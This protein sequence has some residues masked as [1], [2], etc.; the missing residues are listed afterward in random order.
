MEEQIY[1]VAVNRYGIRFVNRLLSLDTSKDKH[2]ILMIC[3]LF[4]EYNDYDKVWNT[5]SRYNQIEQYLDTS[6][7]Q[8]YD[9]YSVDIDIDVAVGTFRMSNNP[10]VLKGCQ[11]FYEEGLCIY[12]PKS[13]AEASAIGGRFWG[14]CADEAIFQKMKASG[15]NL[16]FTYNALVNYTIDY[17]AAIAK[18][19][20]YVDAYNKGNNIAVDPLDGDESPRGAKE[21]REGGSEQ[22]ERNP[23]S[24]MTVYP[25]EGPKCMI[26]RRINGGYCG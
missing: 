19:N 10:N 12:N 24:P 22:S 20:G 3:N 15:A 18:S 9:K 14:F 21:F 17:V 2:Y 8:N 26:K 11:I 6:E 23:C 1:N 25:S 13:F 4:A 5:I 7:V 16:Y